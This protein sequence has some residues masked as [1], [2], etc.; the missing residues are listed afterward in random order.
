MKVL[1]DGRR[2]T[3]FILLISSISF[4][5][6]ELARIQLRFK[7]PGISHFYPQYSQMSQFLMCNDDEMP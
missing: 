2:G 5:F 6:D 3:F 7:E 1:K 4:I